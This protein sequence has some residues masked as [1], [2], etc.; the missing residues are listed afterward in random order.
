[1]TSNP[2]GKQV[3]IGTAAGIAVIV[4]G[5]AVLGMS[6]LVSVVLGAIVYVAVS[7]LGRE[8]N[9]SP[10]EP[11]AVAPVIVPAPAPDSDP[12]APAEEAPEAMPHVGGD[13]STPEHKTAV[14]ENENAGSVRLG[15]LLPGEAEVAARKGSWRYQD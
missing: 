5:A 8:G 2:K 7:R 1:M 13:N 9:P 12:V 3:L 10:Q 15:T 6:L 14:A 11:E 4:I